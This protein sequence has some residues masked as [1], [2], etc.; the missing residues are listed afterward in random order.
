MEES[1]SKLLSLYFGLFLIICRVATFPF[2][3]YTSCVNLGKLGGKAMQQTQ[4]NQPLHY[5]ALQ[6]AYIGDSVFDLMVRSDRL[7]HQDTNVKKLHRACIE[8]VNASSQARALRYLMPYLTQ[9]ETQIAQRGRNA[10]PHTLPKNGDAQEYALATA[11]EAVFGYHY[12]CGNQK[13][14]DEL[15]AYCLLCWQ[16]EENALNKKGDILPL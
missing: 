11:L 13:R 8:R 5:N 12:L 3:W 2:L 15:F 4:Q 7:F 16:E 10:K 14:I 1:L 6:L 9:E